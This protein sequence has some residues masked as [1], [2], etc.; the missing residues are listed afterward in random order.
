M[1]E[2][3]AS[4]F[5]AECDRLGIQSQP[6]DS[7]SSNVRV[8]PVHIKQTHHKQFTVWGDR[9]FSIDNTSG[10]PLH[11]SFS[12]SEVRALR[13]FLNRPTVKRSLGIV[14]LKPEHM[15][16]K[17]EVQLGQHRIEVRENRSL[18]LGNAHALVELDPGETY[19]L[20]TVLHEIFK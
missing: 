17:H 4:A 7:I 12:N 20:F 10:Q 3:N 2:V 18:A 14:Q 8:R 1:V 11:L 19:R 15:S 5:S 9:S 6:D 16:T 13:K